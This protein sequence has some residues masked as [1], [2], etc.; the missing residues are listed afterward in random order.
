[1]A[2]LNWVPVMLSDSVSY[3]N[4]SGTTPVTVDVRAL[5][6]QCTVDIIS[7]FVFKQCV[8]LYTTPSDLFVR[9]HRMKWFHGLSP[10]YSPGGSWRGWEDSNKFVMSHWLYRWKLDQGLY[11]DKPWTTELLSVGGLA[12]GAV[13]ADMV[14]DLVAL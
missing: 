12:Y 2:D 4:S 11:W 1:M 6:K 14:A 10:L 5:G 8:H 13:L 9:E 7:G 3:V